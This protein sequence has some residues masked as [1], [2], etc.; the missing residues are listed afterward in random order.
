MG[1]NIL[2]LTLGDPERVF[3]IDLSPSLV[4]VK[5][6][7]SIINITFEMC[8]DGGSE[9]IKN[10]R[11]VL[12]ANLKGIKKEL[13]RFDWE[14]YLNGPEIDEAYKRFLYVYERIC[15]IKERK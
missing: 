12:R 9:S 4:S 11:D 6:G 3:D 7:H 2:D 5:I 10:K 15:T 1:E 14:S 13:S 8:L